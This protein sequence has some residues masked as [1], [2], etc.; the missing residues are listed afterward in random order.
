M[1]TRFATPEET[2]QWDDLLAQNPDG[3]NVFQA[4]EMA[5]TKRANGWAPRYIM[6]DGLA[7]TALEKRVFAHGALWYLPKGPG[8]CSQT[9]AIAVAR[10]LR[11]FAAQYGVFAIKFEPELPEDTG[12]GALFSEAGFVKTPAVQPNVSTVILDLSPDL[13]TIMISLPQ[14]GR[15]AIKRAQRDG[16]KTRPVPLT[17]ENMQIMFEL[18]SA[19]AK[20]R[21]ESSLRG[22]GYYQAFWQRFAQTGRGQLFFAYVDGNVVAAAYC[23]YLGRK[24]LYKDG[25]SVRERTTYGAS[26]LLQWEVIQWMKARGVTS[27][28]LCGAPHSRHINDETHAFYGVGRFKTSLNK[29]V[30][31]YIGCYDLVINPRAYRRWQRFTQ[32]LV[33]SLSW[34]VKKRQWF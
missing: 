18:L 1:T 19:T 29:L 31:D 5:E 27:Y 21:F 22:F 17:K 3:G 20:G 2:A 10:Q 12:D 23:M 15:H 6:C 32:R 30:T 16:V 13:E 8:V 25:A 9:E 11:P 24:G 14:K 4:Q 34:R 26:H 33:I 7:I 28:D